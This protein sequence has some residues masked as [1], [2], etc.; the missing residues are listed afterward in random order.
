MN[1]TRCHLSS[2]SGCS[3]MAPI[4]KSLASVIRWNGQEWSGRAKTGAVVK[5]WMRAQKAV[6][7]A[8]F[9]MNGVSFFVRSKRGLAMVE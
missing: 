4:A 5:A 3:R 8:P 1:A 6:S 2:A 7:A 9:Q